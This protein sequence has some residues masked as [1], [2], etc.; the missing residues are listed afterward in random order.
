MERAQTRPPFPLSPPK[1]HVYLPNHI[2]SVNHIPGVSET[3]T[4]SHMHRF[5]I[6]I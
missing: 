1:I 4:P 5:S 6:D 3:P 2:R